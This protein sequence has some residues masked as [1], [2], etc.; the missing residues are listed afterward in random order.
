MNGSTV[1][2]PL[3]SVAVN[4]AGL[5]VAIGFKFASP[6]DYGPVYST[7]TDGTT[8]TTPAYIAG[9]LNPALL[10][11]ITVNSSDLFVAVGGTL[12]TPD[13]P[14]RSTGALYA[15]STDGSTWST[16]AQMPGSEITYVMDAITLS[17]SGTFVAVGTDL[18]GT[19]EPIYSTSTD[20]S[21]WTNV[22][23]IGGYTGKTQITSVA[24]NVSGDIVA[25][26]SLI[27]SQNEGYVP[28]YAISYAGSSSWSAPQPMGFPIL[29]SIVVN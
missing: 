10:S 22:A 20:G 2:S 3:T 23:L 21:T 24:I 15:T 7:S 18:A 11:A 19:R 12:S 13:K 6:T 27:N 25:V 8:W 17:P 26:G 5:F 29:K 9:N 28:L 14:V 1:S 16:P 4:S